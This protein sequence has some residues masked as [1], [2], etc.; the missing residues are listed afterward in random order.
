MDPHNASA[1]M[2]SVMSN[3]VLLYQGE[4]INQAT[5]AQP[6]PRLTASGQL[7]PVV[8]SLPCGTCT[9]KEASKHHLIA[10]ILSYNT[11]VTYI[12]KQTI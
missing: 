1:A 5:S 8:M 2:G 11:P 4:A 3:S 10:L 12:L 7:M 9:E 6:L